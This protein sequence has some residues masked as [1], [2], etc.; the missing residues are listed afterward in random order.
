PSRRAASPP[1]AASPACLVVQIEAKG[2][3][4]VRFFVSHWLQHRPGRWQ[5]ERGL[6][7]EVGYAELESAVEQLVNRAEATWGAE[8]GEPTLEFILPFQLLNDAVDWW[9]RDAGGPQAVPFCL[10]Y[11]LV[12]R[13]LERM[14]ATHWHRP[15]RNRWAVLMA[16]ASLTHWGPEKYD[17]EE[18]HQWNITLSADPQ[19]A[20]V[21]LSLPPVR[22]AHPGHVPL[23]MALRAGVPVV[24]WDRRDQ[25]AT[26]FRPTV[27]ELLSGPVVRLPQRI[28]ALRKVA[29]KS[30]TGHSHLGR[31]LAV[32]C[33]D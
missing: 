18:L 3:G 29:A 5:P 11:P 21:A 6:D 19:L 15:W 25:S 17:E 22:Q 23:E 32:L 7:V 16:E 33:D 12:L 8:T 14:R 31:H 1:G 20:S 4:V 28:Q 27:S 13:S 26:E 30:G 9:C 2:S 24:V 10:E